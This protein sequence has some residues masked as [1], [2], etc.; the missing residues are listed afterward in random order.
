MLINSNLDDDEKQE[1]EVKTYDSI[2]ADDSL[3]LID[4]GIGGGIDMKDISPI[5]TFSAEGFNTTNGAYTKYI[6]S[7]YTSILT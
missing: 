2:D 5:E 7:W 4:K 3:N 6:I 1:F